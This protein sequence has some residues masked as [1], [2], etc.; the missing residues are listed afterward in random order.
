MLKKYNIKVVKI[1]KSII[2]LL[3]IYYNKN[4]MLIFY[5]KY[6]VNAFQKNLGQDAK[7]KNENEETMKK[8]LINIFQIVTKIFRFLLK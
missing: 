5:I 8:Y 3:N 1:L 2:K 6:N 4:I 7:N